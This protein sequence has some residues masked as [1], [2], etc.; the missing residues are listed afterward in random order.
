[1]LLVDFTPVSQTTNMSYNGPTPDAYSLHVTS[2]LVTLRS[3]LNIPSLAAPIVNGYEVF[4]NTTLSLTGLTTT[5]SASV[6]GVIVQPLSVGTFTFTAST[7]YGS[8]V[9]LTGTILQQDAS[10]NAASLLTGAPNSSTGGFFA[11]TVTYTG[12]VIYSQ[13]LATPGSLPVGDATF[14]ALLPSTAFT[15]TTYNSKTYLAAFD[16]RVQGQFSTP[17][18]PEPGSFSAL[19]GAGALLLLRRKR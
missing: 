4:A 16:A 6:V 5:S 19:G 8:V 17:V 12:G 15:P 3:A 9:L 10:S 11:T 7:T 1:V 13:L 2:P 18:I 14:S